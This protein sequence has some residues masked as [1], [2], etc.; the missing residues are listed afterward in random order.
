MN[1]LYCQKAHYKHI[2]S[3]EDISRNA[4]SMY[5]LKKLKVEMIIKY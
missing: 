2:H 5:I 1:I 3:L 4:F